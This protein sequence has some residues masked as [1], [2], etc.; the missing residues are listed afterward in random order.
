MTL[1]ERNNLLTVGEAANI[2]H[3]DSNTVRKWCD[4]GMIRSLRIGTRNDRRILETD[5]LVILRRIVDHYERT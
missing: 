1:L 4:S 2:L 3:I 5:V